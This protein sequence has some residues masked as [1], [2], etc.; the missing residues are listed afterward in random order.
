MNEK[1]IYSISKKYLERNIDGFWEDD[2]KIFQDIM[3]FHSELYYEKESP[4]V[5]DNEYDLL[6]KKLESLEDRF[7][8]EFRMTQTVGS[9]WKQSTFNKVAH[10]RPMISLDNTYNSEDLEDFDTRVKRILA[11]EEDLEYTIE[12][13]FD[14]LWVE[15]VYKKWKLTQAITRGNGIQWEDVTE[16]VKQIQNIPQTIEYM[17]DIE[18]RGEVLMPLSSFEKLNK[19]AKEDGE[20]VFANPRNAAS[21]SL[22]ILDTSITKKRDLKFFAYDI[23]DFEGYGEKTYFDMVQS[24]STLWFEISSYFQKCIWIQGIIFQVDSFWEAQKNIDFEIDGLVI[25]VNS[26]ELWKEVGYTEHH[27]RYAISYKFPAEI[28]TTQIESVEHSV[29]RTG[30]ITP[31]AN[32]APVILSGATIRRSTLHNYDEVEKLDVRVGD[33]VFIKRAGEVIPKIVSVVKEVRSW[34]EKV[35]EV[36]QSCPSC[37]EKVYKDEDK[38]RYYCANNISCPGQLREQLA[39]SIGKWGF[40]IDGFWVRQVEVFLEEWLISNLVDIFYLSDKREQILA[41]EWFQETS[42]NNLIEGIEKVKHTDI[43]TF[44]KSIGIPG[45]GKKTAKTLAKVFESTDDILSFSLSA[46]DL[47][48]LWDIGPEIATNV[49]EFFTQRKE[50]LEQLLEVLHIEFLEQIDV[51]GGKYFW[52]KMCITGSFDWYTRDQLVEILEKEWWEF[53]GSVSKKTDYLLA[54]EKAWGKL[55]KAEELGVEVLKIEDFL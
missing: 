5:S 53:V 20:K 47:L 44:L 11:D 22:R 4:I 48:E 25:K 30:T 1:D 38:V 51:S 17:G 2:I 37:G 46:E 13:K 19:Q 28:Q 49:V 7:W 50:Y 41:L 55:K 34:K 3:K 6:F 42:V 43:V 24:L 40:D 52:K 27:P 39:Y 26:I 15:L 10:N 31:V 16:N 36:P 9:Q 12:Y 33:T 21:G 8:T 54:W 14:G 29:G 23:S 32:V 45:V 35:I 18:I